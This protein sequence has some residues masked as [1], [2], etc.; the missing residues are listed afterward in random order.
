MTVAPIAKS[1][2]VAPM[3]SHPY[4]QVRFINEGEADVWTEGKE[5]A[6][7]RLKAGNILA[8]PPLFETQLCLSKQGVLHESTTRKK[9]R[10]SF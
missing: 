9:N 10:E 3:P 7:Q 8:L 5:S 2:C 4:T 1:G 6:K